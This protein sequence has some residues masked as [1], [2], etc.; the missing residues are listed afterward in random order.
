VKRTETTIAAALFTSDC[1]DP[2]TFVR[3]DTERPERVGL[4][5]VVGELPSRSFVAR[6]IEA[7]PVVDP[8]DDLSGKV[9]EWHDSDVAE[10]MKHPLR[11]YRVRV[12]AELEELSQDEAQ[13]WV[14]EAKARDEA[15]L[16]SEQQTKGG[17]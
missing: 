16:A 4:C 6:L 11:V 10:A 14:A 7:R 12:V 8:A 2:P 9:A 3:L 1:D 13:R 15:R 17:E 5:E